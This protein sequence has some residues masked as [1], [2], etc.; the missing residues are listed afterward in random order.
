VNARA[1]A[2]D[3]AFAKLAAGSAADRTLI[4]EYYLRTLSRFPSDEER[5]FWQREL[6]AGDRSQKCEDFAWSLLSS[7]EFVTNH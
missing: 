5:S 3:S 6:A 2:P 1:A 7:R 4:E